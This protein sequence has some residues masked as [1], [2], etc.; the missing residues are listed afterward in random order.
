MALKL[1]QMRFT[2]P[3]IIGPDSRM[4]MKAVRASCYRSLGMLKVYTM[5]LPLVARSITFENFSMSLLEI[6]PD[7]L[8]SRSW[9]RVVLEKS[10]PFYFALFDFSE[11]RIYFMDDL[12]ASLDGV[13][14]GFVEVA[15]GCVEE[16][17]E[18]VVGEQG[19]YLI[20]PDNTLNESNEAVVG[21]MNT[22][23]EDSREE[24]QRVHNRTVST[25]A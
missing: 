20:G 7:M 25:G 5:L 19:Y 18:G 23:V 16:L 14:V 12:L 11:D 9:S 24:G 10:T 3:T 4:E 15:V 17:H 22:M 21:D 1:S 2:F 6:T 13:V 8:T